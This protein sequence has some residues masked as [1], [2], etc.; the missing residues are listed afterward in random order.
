ME[1]GDVVILRLEVL[2]NKPGTRGVVFNS[3]T[4]FDDSSKEG[5]QI[6]FENGEYGGF[7]FEQQELLL[8]KIDVK[9]IPSSIRNYIFTNVMKVDQ[10]WE[11][12]FWDEI[13]R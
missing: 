12:G 11:A 4:D 5:H 7:S 13:F 9:Y 10:D 2:L 3:Y 6:I 8:E 1:I